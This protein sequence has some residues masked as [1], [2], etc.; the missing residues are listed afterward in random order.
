[1]A[2]HLRQEL[3]IEV[4]PDARRARQAQRGVA[5][6]GGAQVGAERFG[7]QIRAQGGRP[8]RIG[9]LQD[10]VLALHEA[11]S[12]SGE[13]EG[14]QETEQAEQRGLDDPDL[15]DDSAPRLPRI[16]APRPIADLEREEQRR[17]QREDGQ[18][19]VDA[20]L[21]DQVPVA[22]ARM[23]GSCARCNYLAAHN[24]RLPG[25]LERVTRAFAERPCSK[26]TSADCGGRSQC[27][28][29]KYWTARSWR[30]A[31]ASEE[32]VPRLRRLRVLGSSL[33]E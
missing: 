27:A 28:R 19:L 8:N 6:Q 4:G 31:A 9:F 25:P 16:L 33:R 21:H 7:D 17:E 20:G 12:G 10:Q 5:L 23:R 30:F 29:L 14:Q 22:L 1:M 11:R 15:R 13:A 2:L 3:R 18:D 32:K 26:A 24:L